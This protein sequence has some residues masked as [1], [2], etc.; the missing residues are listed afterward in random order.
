MSCIGQNCGI[1]GFDFAG[2]GPVHMSSGFAGL[3]FSLFLG[4]RNKGKKL[5]TETSP[6]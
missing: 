1:G 4:K 5:T 6:F 3:A 2:G